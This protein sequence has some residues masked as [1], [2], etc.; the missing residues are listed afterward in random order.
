MVDTADR[1]LIHELEPRNQF[2]NLRTE[3]IPLLVRQALC[4]ATIHRHEYRILA[5]LDRFFR[6]VCGKDLLKGWKLV[7]MTRQKNIT[8]IYAAQP[9]DRVLALESTNRPLIPKSHNL[10]LPRSSINKFDGFMSLC[11]TPCSSFRYDNA[12]T[13]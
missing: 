7:S 1:P 11:I 2:Y 5:S 8:A 6:A 13:V 10:M 4:P 12:L 9:A 3:M